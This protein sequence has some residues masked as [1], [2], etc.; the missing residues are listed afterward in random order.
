MFKQKQLTNLLTKPFNCHNSTLVYTTKKTKISNI[1][2]NSV[3]RN[4]QLLKKNSW[5]IAR[6]N[7][8]IKYEEEELKIT[9]SKQEKINSKSVLKLNEEN[10][11]MKYRL[12][13]ALK[14]ELSEEDYSLLLK[15]YCLNMG[16]EVDHLDSDEEKEFIYHQLH[17][18]NT[19]H[20]ELEEEA[21]TD[22]EK[23]TR[24]EVINAFKLLCGSEKF[25]EFLSKKYPTFKRYSGEGINTL[26]PL[27]QTILSGFSDK[28]S[29]INDVVI[30]MGHRGRINVM[31]MI[32]DFPVRNLLLKFDSKRDIPDGIPGICD[33]PTH[34]A[35]SRQ[36]AFCI[37]GNIN[38]SKEIKVSM[39]HNPSHL[40]MN[41]P[42]GIGK[43]VAKRNDY[44]DEFSNN[45][46]EELAEKNH[47][48]ANIAIHGDAAVSGQG[49]IYETLS[50]MGKQTY[51]GT[52]HIITNN[53][54]G[55]T[56][57]KHW[58]KPSDIF[59]SFDIPV[60]H[61]NS[62]SMLDVLKAAKLASA[63]QKKFGKDFVIDLIGWRKYGHNEVDEPS[64]TQPHMYKIIRSIKSS[65][66]EL[67]EKLISTN[68]L[69]KEII[70]N[71]EKVYEK[72]L[73]KEFELS[74][75]LN[76]KIE[77]T[78][79][80]KYL[81][82][83]SL[84]HKWKNIKFPFNSS[85]IKNGDT[86]IS[87]DLV[88]K[89]LKESINLPSNFNIHPRLKNYFINSRI[90]AIEKDSI[91]WASAEIAA[92]A[93]LLEDGYNVRISGQD[94][95]RGTFNQRH[96]GLVDQVTNE[97]IYPLENKYFKTNNENSSNKTSVVNNTG[98]FEINNS[99]L[100]ELGVLLYEYGYSLENPNNLVL[101]EAQFGDF[102]NVC[103]LVFDQYL[104]CAESKW[105]RQSAITIL[106]PHGFDGAGPEHSSSRVERL[107]QLVNHQGH[108][109]GIPD[110]RS[111]N[112]QVVFP[113]T[114]ANYFHIIRRQLKRD[115]RKPLIIVTPKI[116]LKHKLYSSKLED[117]ESEYKPIIT[118]L[119]ETNMNISSSKDSQINVSGIK[120]VVFTSGQSF[121]NLVNM[122]GYNKTFTV[123][124]IE[125]LAPFP[126]KEI[127]DFLSKSF[128]KDTQFVYFQEESM[129]AGTFYYCLPYLQKILKDNGFKNHHNIEYIGRD[130]QEAAN[131]CV[132]DH[133][134][135]LEKIVMDLKNKLI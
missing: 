94:C 132:N 64:F 114:A 24:T 72:H 13:D 118:Y 71:T 29:P 128:N 25:E 120:R 22:E 126:I 85:Y 79:N 5:K 32:L 87:R 7:P 98:R 90:D 12:L 18:L 104:S 91:D 102:S 123:I 101:W 63:Y 27:I 6:T 82:S 28:D 107:L 77:D 51:S 45:K 134:K 119:N 97:K 60:I 31:A 78:T 92:F 80:D 108:S 74:K 117:F 40:E 21:L 110:C 19:K 105:L 36:K 30:S 83:T 131:G 68:I 43:C 48:V 103:Q 99:V 96:I 49:V 52:I 67:K 57:E 69:T 111:I 10:I 54:L 113:T 95:M 8:L 39:I 86:K 46:L 62:N 121:M 135:E 20:K 2:K 65:Y 26:I 115:Y 53:Q 33:I 100:S 55:F 17:E 16:I 129:N 41:Y 70:T 75:T 38:K 89:Y 66:E 42:M 58:T 35:K 73:E 9:S 61:V 15:S 93:S 122:E 130:A 59:K 116:G 4:I 84:S 133:K 44:Y 124:R 56:T 50:L 37:N 34:L 76:L 11:L 23:V 88:V 112:M 3:E 127:S 1:E 125:E 81:G 47:K 109:E 106:L 14:S